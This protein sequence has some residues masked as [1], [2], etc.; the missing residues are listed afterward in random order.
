MY[1]HR[2]T[3]LP[4]KTELSE[5]KKAK[6]PQLQLA[7][8]AATKEVIPPPP[9]PTIPE[10]P[11]ASKRKNPN[12]YDDGFQK[13]TSKKTNPRKGPNQASETITVVRGKRQEILS[14]YGNTIA[15]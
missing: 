6:E 4:S 10:Q 2:H 5:I 3:C 8:E 13:V 11:H 12:Y 15:L 9:A 7:A 14:S 1:L